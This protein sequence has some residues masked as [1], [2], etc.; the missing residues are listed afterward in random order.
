MGK[1][2]RR[3]GKQGQDE[4]DKSPGGDQAALQGNAGNGKVEVFF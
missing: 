3:Q 1:A 4:E 2:S